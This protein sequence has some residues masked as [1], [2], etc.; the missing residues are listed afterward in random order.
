VATTLKDIAQIV[1]GELIGGSPDT[2]VTD[3][4][5]I[6]N[7][8]LDE[9]TFVGNA[10][11]FKHLNST[12][13]AAVILPA[14]YSGEFTPRISVQSPQMAVRTLVDYFRK[15]LS[16]TFTGIHP[17][18]VI[19]ET[20]ELGSSV[21]IGPHTVISRGAKIDD[22][23]ILGASVVV[24]QECRIGADCHVY[25]NVTLYDKTILEDRVIVHSG[26]IL[27]SDGYSYVYDDGVHHKIR[28]VGRV[29][30]ESDVEIGANCSIDR[31]ALGETVIGA[32]SKLDNLIQIGHNVK[33]GKGCLI[34]SQVGISGSTILGDYVTIGG[35]AGIIGHITIGDGAVVASQ[36]GV[37]KDVDPGVTV[38]G[39][40]AKP[41]FQA[42]RQEAYLR[43]IPDLVARIKALEE[44]TQNKESE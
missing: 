29:R 4:A 13:A 40:P 32:G 31:A 26:T 5:E 8:K 38:S 33:M 1:D 18:A 39:Y 44:V 7:A 28:Q 36:A 3:I 41:H 35:Q 27:G 23:T 2:E 9:I 43:K 25:S 21:T 14:D 17:T 34:V 20:A 16:P 24:G 19:D 42:R 15:P 30:I 37:T 11:Y 22:N 10:K 12:Q 6:Q